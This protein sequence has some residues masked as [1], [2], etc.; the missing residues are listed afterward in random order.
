MTDRI[1][2]RIKRH[3]GWRAMPYYDTLGNKTIG[4]GT[5]LPL[6]EEEGEWL[7]RHRLGLVEEE[8]RGRLDF[9][10]RMPGEIK[11]VLLDMAYNMGV[12]RLLKFR[13]TLAAAER[14]DWATMAQEMQDSHWFRQVGRRAEELVATV[15]NFEG[16]STARY[17]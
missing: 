6:N 17:A 15:E 9:Y 1:V 3:E 7:L 13:K 10:D 11:E 5:L 14:G 16:A 4:Y 8:L 2:E 12:P